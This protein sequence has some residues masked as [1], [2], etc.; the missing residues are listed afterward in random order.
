MTGRPTAGSEPR[1]CRKLTCKAVFLNP[2]NCDFRFCP[3]CRRDDGG[4]AVPRLGSISG[5]V[6]ARRA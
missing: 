6:S 2:A 3:Q 4:M 5:R 1:T